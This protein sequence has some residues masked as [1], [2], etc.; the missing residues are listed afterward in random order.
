MKWKLGAEGDKKGGKYII[1]FNILW[2]ELLKESAE[3]KEFLSFFRERKPDLHPIYIR[4]RQHDTT[5]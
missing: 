5:K 4:I 2:A 1:V 3:K